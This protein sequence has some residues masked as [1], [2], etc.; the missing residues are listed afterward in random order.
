MFG[1]ASS[2]YKKD[3]R[4]EPSNKKGQKM[5]GPGESNHQQKSEAS[6]AEINNMVPFK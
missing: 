2:G 6:N 3:I 4:R 1:E 5:S